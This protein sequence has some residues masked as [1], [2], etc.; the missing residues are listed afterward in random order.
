MSKLFDLLKFEEGYRE[1][2][3]HCTE[4]YP[5]IGI[6]TKLGPKGTP[7]DYYTFS[8]SE[9]SAKEMLNDELRGFVSKLISQEWYLKLNRDRQIIIKSMC[10]QMGYSGVM[11][12]KKMISAAEAQDWSEMS[13]QALDSRWAKQTPKRANRHAEVLLTGNLD[14]VYKGLI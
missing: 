3:Y 4:G 1:K 8:V 7:L 14:E 10:Y 2:A 5:T 13:K 11:K 9:K 6:G 12:F